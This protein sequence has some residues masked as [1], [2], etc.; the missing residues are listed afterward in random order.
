VIGVG[1]FGVGIKLNLQKHLRFRLE[2]HDYV[3][4][5]PHKVITAAPGTSISGGLN[6]ILGTASIALTW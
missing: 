5:R 1:D 6:D 4:H 2:A 3:G